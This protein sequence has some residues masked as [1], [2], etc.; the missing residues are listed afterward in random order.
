MPK[1]V[2]AT[3]DYRPRSSHA[4]RLCSILVAALACNTVALG[5]TDG[6][7]ASNSGVGV[8][9]PSPSPELK[10]KAMDHFETGLKLYEDGEFSLALIEFDRA[11]SYVPDYRVLYNIGQV[12]IQLGRYARA[13]DAL[14]QYL[15]QGGPSIAPARV[16]AVKTDLAM[17]EGRTA[18]LRVDCRVTGAEVL[19]DDVRI[20]T[21]PFEA[22]LLVDAGE[23]RLTVQKP[24]YLPRTERLV[25]AGRDDHTVR[26]DL[27]EVV[28]SLTPQKQPPAV[29]SVPKRLEQREQ[30]RLSLT[31]STLLYAG[32]G[33]TGVLALGWAITGYLGIRAA[34]DLHDEL[35]RPSTESRLSDL[36]SRAQ[37]L[38]LASDILGACAIGVGATTMYFALS[39]NTSQATRRVGS[40]PLQI[41]LGPA[42]VQL[43]GSFR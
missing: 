39:S 20:A 18:H 26:V 37:G 32:T 8:E 2:I 33:A 31:R 24:G 30:A 25:L 42:A 40:N 29:V 15:E 10:K 35:Q 43:Q 9:R 12:S 1:S 14:S 6:Q 13:A 36:K 3:A 41:G 19:M 16:E 11:Y 28:A 38:L 34:G 17:L 22:P 5:A 4:A 27:V 23:H 21:T 7:A